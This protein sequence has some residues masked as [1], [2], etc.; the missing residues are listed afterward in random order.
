[1]TRRA[2]SKLPAAGRHPRISAMRVKNAAF[3]RTGGVAQAA[4][5]EPRPRNFRQLR[6]IV[7]LRVTVPPLGPV[8][9][10]EE[11]QD[12]PAQFVLP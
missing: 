9:V 1:M 4:K 2:S 8:N 6:V 11:L 7:P 10:A 12:P 5:T 3:D